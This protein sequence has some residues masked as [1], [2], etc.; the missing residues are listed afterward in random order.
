MN[1]ITMSDTAAVGEFD[2]I[3]PYDDHEVPEVMARLMDDP[4]FAK[5]LLSIKHPVLCRYFSPL[6][7]PYIRRLLHKRFDSIRCVHDLQMLIG[8]Q[9]EKMLK[10]SDSIF[11]VSGL[12]RLDNNNAYLFISNHRDIA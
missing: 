6:L 10:K 3:R 8:E 4:E 2:D 7:T 5:T 11:T 9:M 1:D 12:E